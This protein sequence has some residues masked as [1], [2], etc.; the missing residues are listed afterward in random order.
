MFELMSDAGCI[1][2][3][4]SFVIPTHDDVVTDVLIENSA[5]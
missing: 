3:K 5:R 2:G 1:H 4:K